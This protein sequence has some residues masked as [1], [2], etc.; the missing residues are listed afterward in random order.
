MRKILFL[1]LLIPIFTGCDEEDIEEV[2]EEP[3]IEYLS[4]EQSL[5]IKFN[6]NSLNGLF[7]QIELE[8]IRNDG[9]N[10]VEYYRTIIND[11]IALF[12]IYPDFQYIGDERVSSNYIKIV[13][14]GNYNLENLLHENLSPDYYVSY[15][16]EC[17]PKD[18]FIQNGISVP[19][20]ATNGCVK[21]YN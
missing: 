5:T 19:D 17:Y 14:L 3:K 9:Y 18:L 21:F 11:N 20:Y 10:T 12:T 2:Q 4:I 7:L 6:D 15:E 8:T 13:Q 1:F 16:L